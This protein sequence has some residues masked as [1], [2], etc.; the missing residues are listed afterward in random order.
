M[1]QDQR[2]HQPEVPLESQEYQS[3]CREKPQTCLQEEVWRLEAPIAESRASS[4]TW[5]RRK[6]VH[7]FASL[8]CGRNEGRGE[9]IRRTLR[10]QFL[11]ASSYGLSRPAAA[12]VP[13]VQDS[14]QVARLAECVQ[15]P[16]RTRAAASAIRRI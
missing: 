4:P 5:N 12:R 3:V 10:A 13:T 11:L 8:I 1:R 16:D 7:C 15:Q 2:L 14:M 9:A 6:R